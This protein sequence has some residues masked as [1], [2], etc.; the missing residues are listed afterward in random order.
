MF[1]MLLVIQTVV[2]LGLFFFKVGKVGFLIKNWGEVI[3][4][5]PTGQPV[6]IKKG[7]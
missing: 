7:R 2:I 1:K 3:K 6:F 4:V 5:G